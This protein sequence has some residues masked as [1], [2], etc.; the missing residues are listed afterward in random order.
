GAPAPFS[1]NLVRRSGCAPAA[2]VELTVSRPSTSI[3]AC[4][5]ATAAASAI[6][7]SS[8]SRIALRMPASPLLMGLLLLAPLLLLLIGLALH[9]LVAAL[10]LVL[11][12]DQG[13]ADGGFAR[14]LDVRRGRHGRR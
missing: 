2:E 11:G 8:G 10:D 6:A 14:A 12:A 4:A 7:A 1:L 5:G 9:T 3:A 13:I